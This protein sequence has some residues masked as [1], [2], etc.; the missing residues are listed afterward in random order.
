M[1][2]E[3]QKTMLDAKGGVE[4]ELLTRD[5]LIRAGVL[6]NERF[7]VAQHMPLSALVS[8]INPDRAQ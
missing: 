7:S 6:R 1:M 5:L 2:S 3:Q 4:S 8:Y